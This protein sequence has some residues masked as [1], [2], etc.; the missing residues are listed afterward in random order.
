MYI[1]MNQFRVA[2]ARAEDFET[3]WR[4]RDS[5][6]DEAKGFGTFELLKGSLDEDSGI[7]LYS[8]HTTW[9][10]EASFRAWV[11]SDAFRKAHAQGSLKGILAGPP[12][13][14]GWTTVDLGK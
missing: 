11:D 3:A 5:Y 4:E 12:Q 8:S 9:D 7:R 14:F 6:L 10:D 13:F 1:A 2:E